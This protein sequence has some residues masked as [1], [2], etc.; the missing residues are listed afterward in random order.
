MRILDAICVIGDAGHGGTVP[1]LL[2][3]QM[4]Q[5]GVDRAILVPDDRMTAVENEEGNRYVLDAISQNP[6]SFCGF[7][8]TNPWFGK[9]AEQW[10]RAALDAGLSGLYLK[11]TVQGFMVDDERLSPLLEIC[12]ERAVPAYFHTGTP[13]GAL[14]FGVLAQARR[15]PEVNFI[16]GHMGANDYV[17][18]AFA[19]V[20]LCDNVY[21]ETSLNLTTLIRSAAGIRPERVLYGSSSPR[22]NMA[23]ELKKVFEAVPNEETRALLLHA[24]LERLL[25]GRV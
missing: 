21:L 6:D 12:R 18:D 17:G 24:N 14:P 13:V 15:F 20:N 1:R 5:N 23:F 9:R 8:V 2:L 25:G 3:E 22:G 16:L 19:A 4:R 11:S 7:A 10:L